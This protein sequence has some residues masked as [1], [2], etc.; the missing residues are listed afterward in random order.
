MIHHSPP[1]I[2]LSRFLCAGLFALAAVAC[3]PKAQEPSAHFSSPASPQPSEA[4]RRNE[5]R[6]E[7]IAVS[8]DGNTI[9]FQF[10]PAPKAPGGFKHFGIGLYEWRTGKLTRIPNP[11]DTRLGNPS[12]SYD[13]KQ[14]AVFSQGL[15]DGVRSEIA[16]VDLATQGVTV[17][18]HDERS[19]HVGKTWPVFQPETGNI[20]YVE[21]PIL[22]KSGLKL[23]NAKG[24]PQQTLIEPKTGFYSIGTPFFVAKD[25]I[26]FNARGPADKMVQEAIARAGIRGGDQ[27][28]GEISYE[29]M[30][31]QGP[32]LIFSQV[33]E[34]VFA[35][36]R[37]PNGT[38]DSSAFPSLNGSRNGAVLVHDWGTIAFDLPGLKRHKFTE[39]DV[40]KL[41]RDGNS[42]PLTHVRSHLFYTRISYDG[43]VV[44]FLTDPTRENVFDLAVLDMSTGQVT[45]TGLLEKLK[46]DPRFNT[47]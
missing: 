19:L 40:Y 27:A 41:D 34:N 3:G 20:L 11:P 39:Y 31:S 47:Y 32:A 25:K 26:Y 44:A 2:L 12:F 24:E 23:I 30:F 16:T 28:A 7:A 43:S 36:A 21:Q 14:L 17:L 33:Q 1:F 10:E 13:G 15:E 46:A 18:T 6:L 38:H 45:A 4:V 29:L 42:T 5:L 9:A 35:H 22:S 8:P 37:G